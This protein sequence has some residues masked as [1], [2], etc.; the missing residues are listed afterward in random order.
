MVKLIAL[1]KRNPGISREDFAQRWVNEHTKLSS[2]I[3]NVRGYYINI[4]TPQQP[5]GTGDEPLYDGTAEMWW[6]SIQDMEDA[7]A[8]EIGQR[9]GADA[10]EFCS[11]RM[12]LYTEEHTIIPFKGHAPRGAAKRRA[13]VKKTARRATRKAKAPAKF[14]RARK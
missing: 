3:P 2:K 14:G 1:L 12:H 4:C 8:T 6:D 7:F 10:D 13:P 5:E 9:A 11:V